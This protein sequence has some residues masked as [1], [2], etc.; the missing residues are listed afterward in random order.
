MSNSTI[1]SFFDNLPE[2]NGHKISIRGEDGYFD[3]TTMSKAMP[4]KG[5]KPRRFNDWTKTQFAKDLLAEISQLSGIPIDYDNCRSQS[6][7]PLIDYVRGGQDGIWLHPYV[8]MSY[9][10][11]DPRFQARINIWVIELMK[12]GTVNPHYLKWSPEE[13]QR[14]LTFNR[15]D[16][17]DMYGSR[18]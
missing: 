4:T 11:S 2:Y 12:T 3:A 9:A 18:D 5:G 6:Q 14:G 15:D 13:F 8:A 16:I 10:M 1:V 7:S 17:D